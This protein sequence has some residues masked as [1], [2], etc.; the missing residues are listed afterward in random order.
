MRALLVLALAGAAGCTTPCDDLDAHARACKLVP[1]R[2]SDDRFAACTAVRQETAAF[3]AFAACVEQAECAD[4]SAV[5]R[6]EAEHVGQAD[7]CLHYRLWGAACGLEPSGTEEQC[8]TLRSAMTDAVFEAWVECI[9]ADGCP[10]GNDPRYDVCQDVLF[11]P[12]AGQLIDACVLIIEWTRAC[13]DA[14]PDFLPVTASNVLECVAQAGPFSSESFLEYATCLAEIACDDVPGRLDCLLGL[15]V[16]DPGD[17]VA[18]CERLVAYSNTCGV[19]L[20]GGSVEACSRLFARFTPASLG[21]FVDCVETY[22]CGDPAAAAD[23]AGLLE[24]Q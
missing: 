12:A 22:E 21:A 9:T 18:P 20:G 3:D 7:A 5:D 19:N 13:A 14:A 2:Y 8:A 16:L 11:P 24:L 10:R 1:S 15:E 23:C 4:R 6:C 17:A